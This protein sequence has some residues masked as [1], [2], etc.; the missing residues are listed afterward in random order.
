M[1]ENS[2]TGYIFSTKVPEPLKGEGILGAPPRQLLI[3]TL[4]GA[5]DLK[6]TNLIAIST[7]ESYH[8]S[9]GRYQEYIRGIP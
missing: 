8:D 3:S 5:M 4:G 7:S 2:E 1:K 9:S 6:L